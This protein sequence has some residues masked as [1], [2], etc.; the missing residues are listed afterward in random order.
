MLS[1]ARAIKLN[2]LECAG[3]SPREVTLCHLID[4]PL[5]PFRFGYSVKDRRFEVR[6]LS[7][8]KRYP[9]EF[10]EIR[11]AI[12]QCPKNMPK[13]PKIEQMDALSENN[14]AEDTPDSLEGEEIDIDE[15]FSISRKK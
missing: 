2:C 14:A 9:D 8:Q 12:R 5:W 13:S 4:C 15:F 1:R 3:G 11:E 7:A 6:M 10:A